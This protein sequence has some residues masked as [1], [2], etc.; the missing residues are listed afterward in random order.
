MAGRPQTRDARQ[1]LERVLDQVP[2]LDA[3]YKTLIEEMFAA[4]RMREVSVP[5]TCKECGEQ[6]KYVIQVPLPDLVSR[7]KGLDM[8]LTQAKGKP[9][10]TKLIDLNVTAAHT[11]AELEGMSDEQLALLAAAQVEEETDGNQG[12]TH[13]SRKAAAPRKDRSTKR[14]PA[15]G[16]DGSAGKTG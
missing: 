3:K 11:R 16:A 7:V 10:E 12:D 8:L 5:I 6:R 1:T 9:A 14:R 4:E 13:T 2:D 15:A